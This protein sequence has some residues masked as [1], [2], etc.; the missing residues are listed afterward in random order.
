[1]KKIKGIKAKLLLIAL[2]PT[3]ATLILLG[4]SYFSV[5]KLSHE[6]DLAY[7]VYVPKITV[8]GDV[9]TF[10][11]AFAYFSWA[12]LGTSQDKAAFDEFVDDL[13]SA[14]ENFKKSINSYK[15]S[16]VYYNEAELMAGVNPKLDRINELSTE[17]LSL[18]SKNDP[19][20]FELARAQLNGGEWHQ[21]VSELRR[22]A[23][24]VIELY[25]QKAIDA[26]RVQLELK[27]QIFLLIGVFGAFS[28]L[29]VLFLMYR[30][31]SQVSNR[32]GGISGQLAD[33]GSHLKNAIHQLTQSGQQL[34][35][36]A[37]GMASSLEETVASL[38]EMTSMVKTSSE[39]ARQVSS[40][41]QQSLVSAQTGDEE[42]SKL[43]IAMQEITDSSQKI[44]QIITVIDDI[45]FQTNL[46]A[47]NAAVEA[48][49]AGEQ[50]RGFAVVADAVRALASRS[51]EAAKD[52]KGLIETSV[53]KVHGGSEVAKRS[54]EMMKQLGD[55]IRKVSELAS[56]IATAAEEQK[57]GIEQISSAMNVIDQG[58]QGN[59]ASSE[60][61]A[62]TAEEISSQVNLTHDLIG[63]LEK[64]VTGQTR[65]A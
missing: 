26:D 40:L 8:L 11:N 12:A 22:S 54:G 27:A 23:S 60:E 4:I 63:G 41:A 44:E 37:S 47:L 18:I 36:Q 48:A 10:R 19:A 7:R 13:K 38:E 57:S 34:S 59:A 55:S 6:L 28:I 1:M 43:L 64:E 39:N 14:E 24:K 20:A 46:L 29:V 56:E 2:V 25:N 53:D 15:A 30:I 58:A 3:A 45:A 35:N 62:A 21:A 9:L 32:V 65:A 61:I 5:T 49:R 16:P 51:A 33:S 31:A 17:I 50:G 42:M 52:I